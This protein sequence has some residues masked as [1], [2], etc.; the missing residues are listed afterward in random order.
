MNLFQTFLSISKIK[1]FIQLFFLLYYSLYYIL[2]FNIINKKETRNQFHLTVLVVYAQIGLNVNWNQKL[3]IC[4]NEIA[5][6]FLKTKIFII[7][8]SSHI[9]RLVLIWIHLFFF[10]LNLYLILYV[11]TKFVRFYQKYVYFVWL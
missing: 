6:L 1:T 7:Y 4:I 9:F 3:L 10:L 5:S 2:C 11:G 8:Y